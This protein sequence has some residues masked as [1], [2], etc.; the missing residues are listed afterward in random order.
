MRSTAN[1]AVMKK[2]KKIILVLALVTVVTGVS[3][4]LYVYL[5]P[6][7]DV[8]NEKGVQLSAQ[9]LYDAFKVN[10]TEAN[11]K[12]LDKAIEL[13]GEVGDVSVNQDGF[14]VVNFKTN[15]PLIVIN[16][17]FKT[18]PGVLKAGQKITFK[19]ICTGYVPDDKV[20]INQ[21]VLVK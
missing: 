1:Q 19:G 18:N 20:S 4:V 3:I 12:Y 11:A 16:C 9:S 7:R 10:E 13:S 21:G 15:D 14:T 2:W 5:K 17:T 8:T 6:H